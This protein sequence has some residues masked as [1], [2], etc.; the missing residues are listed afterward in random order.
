VLSQL[1]GFTRDVREPLTDTVRSAQR[2]SQVLSEN[3][4]GIDDFLQSVTALSQELA[5]VSG[6]LDGTIRAAEELLTSIDPRKIETIVGNVETFT[7]TLG[8]SSARFDTIMKGV[9]TA[10]ASIGD[11]AAG[12][13]QTIAKVDG[14]LAGVDAGTVRSALSNIERASSNADRAAAD[15]ARVTEK[16]GP[17]ADD[18]DRI[19]SDAGELASRLA[20]ASVR[21]DGVLAKADGVL[22]SAG[23]V[24]EGVDANTVRKALS[25]IE[26]ASANADKAA[27]DIA[28]VTDDLRA[29]EVE[30][31]VSDAGELADRLN[32]ASVRVDGILAKVDELL[33]SGEAE[34]VITQASETLRG[35]Q[36]VADTLNS[37]LGTITEGLAR[38]SGQGLRDVE[39][40]VRDSR[41]SINRI[42]QAVSDIE[43]NPQRIIT[44]GQGEV[45]T[46]DG[47]ARR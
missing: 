36:Q 5:G 34:G 20:E 39:A 4:D 41:R 2:F 43:R 26:R 24:L 19:I 35:F 27:A 22:T 7:D 31:I 9:D 25:N 42:E 8:E 17:R 13:E 29:D 12:A 38:F 11:F 46:Y 28:R 15:I 21:V 44:G 6:K 47:R 16:I 45:R 14:I 3:A 32:R 23:G 1:E 37:R 33:G 30:Q 10:V 40:L 18:I